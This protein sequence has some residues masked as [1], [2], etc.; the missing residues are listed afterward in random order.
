MKK[1]SAPFP[2]D[3]EYVRSVT[4]RIG[5]A[6]L[7]ADEKEVFRALFEGG[8]DYGA[9]VRAQYDNDGPALGT[10]KRLEY[11]SGVDAILGARVSAKRKPLARDLSLVAYNE[12][13]R[14]QTDSPSSLEP[15]RTALA[16]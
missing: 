16:A 6:G 4:R 7:S 11:E 9:A 8:C 1:F 10:L 15:I 5:Q 12:A 14:C 2:V 13:H 3:E